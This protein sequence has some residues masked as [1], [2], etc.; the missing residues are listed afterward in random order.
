[1]LSGQLSSLVFILCL[2]LL[3]GILLLVLIITAI[4][5]AQ[6]GIMLINPPYQ[7]A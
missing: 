5:L 1:M 6:T 7:L 3:V 4:H 2:A